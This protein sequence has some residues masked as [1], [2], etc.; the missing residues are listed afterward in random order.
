MIVH[1]IPD[2]NHRTS[3]WVTAETFRI[4]A[5]DSVPP[6]NTGQLLLQ[7]TMSS[8]GHF[9]VALSDSVN[10]SDAFS[11]CYTAGRD[12]PCFVVKNTVSLSNLNMSMYCQRG[13]YLL[14][15]SRFK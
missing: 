12:P 6:R 13:H 9:L 1:C 5:G 11:S 10:G 3:T 8:K 4:M 14:Q 15:C 7:L 2:D